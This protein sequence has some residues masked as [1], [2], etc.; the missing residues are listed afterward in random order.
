MKKKRVATIKGQRRLFN[1]ISYLLLVLA[2]FSVMFPLLW[3][4]SGSFKPLWQI[5]EIPIRLIPQTWEE[6][7]VQNTGTTIPLW[8]V[9]TPE[10]TK[11]VIEIGA[12]R[13]TTVVDL[14]QLQ[15]LQSVPRDQLS[16]AV[17][18]KVGDVTVNVRNWKSPT[19]Q[20]ARVVAVGRDPEAGDHLLVVPVGEAE[21]VFL[22]LP[23]DQIN[24]APQ[25]KETIQGAELSGRRFEIDGQEMTVLSIGPE[26]ELSVVGTPDIVA[27]ARLIPSNLLG[28]RE[29]SP[30]GQTEISIYPIEGEPEDFRAVVLSQET[31]QPLL[32]QEIV[33]NHAI[34]AGI[35]QIS[36]EKEEQTFNNARMA[37]ATYT[38]QDGSAPFPV[39]ILGLGSNNYLVIPPERLEGIRLGPLTRLTEPRGMHLGPMTYPVIENYEEGDRVSSVAL[40]GEMQ[41]MALVAPAQAVREAFDISPQEKQRSTHISFSLRGYRRLF[42]TKIYDVP[43][44][45]FFLNSGYLVVMNIIGHLVSCTLVAYGFARMRAPGKN[46]LFVILIGTMMIPYTVLLVPIYMVFRDLHMLGTM[47]PLYI[48]SFTGNAFLIFMLR[49]FFMT[50]PYEL[51]EAAIMDGASR[52]QV[53]TR[54]ILP[55]STPALLTM[56]IFTFWWVW[57]SF[58]EPLIYIDRSQDYTITMALNTFNDV[59]ARAGPYYD[60]LL[61]GSVISMLPLI[62]AFFLAQRYFVEGI[63][64]TGLKG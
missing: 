58:L 50:I 39:A 48:R 1:S 7:P 45:R 19:G 23:L 30:V 56:C 36:R 24:K 5:M 9:Q 49:Q 40:V 13:Y 43:F 17:A 33:E 55:L 62:I 54:I 2:S 29:Y 14:A 4:L 60:R 35:G 32:D 46:I 41:E 64:L 16:D 3:L 44:Y 59:Y 51:D 61:A 37:V 53:L 22:Q 38:P 26:T 18:T 31:W 10:G 63:Q 28:N 42:A 57:N 34:I 27:D 6:I 47:M 11:K 21:G 8:K 12:R 15:S 25:Q 20:P 52:L